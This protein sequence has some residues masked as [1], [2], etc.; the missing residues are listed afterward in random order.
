MGDDT[1]RVR[2]N[3]EDLE[4]NTEKLVPGD[5]IVVDAGDIAPC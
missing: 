3:G 4:I 1:V 2:R 5:I